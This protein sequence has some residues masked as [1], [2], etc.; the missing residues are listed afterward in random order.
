MSCIYGPHQRGNED[1]GWVAH[2]MRSA[3]TDGTLNIFGDGLQVRDVLYVDDL[4]DAFMH[5]VDKSDVLAGGTFNIGGGPRNTLSL[6]ELV[7]HVKEHAQSSLDVQYYDA[8][9]GDQ[10]YYV[11]DT[12]A[13]ARATGWHPRTDVARG[14][15]KLSDWIEQA[16]GV[17]VS[18]RKVGAVAS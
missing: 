17:S 1:Q 12:D 6:L 5:A 4:V 3:R 9:T 2:F 16:G 7:N 11:S 10:R 13:F 8:R 14:L 15:S 18:S